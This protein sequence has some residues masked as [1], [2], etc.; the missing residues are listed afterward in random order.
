MQNRRF[1]GEKSLSNKLDGFDSGYDANDLKE[2]EAMLESSSNKTIF[3]TIL[4]YFSLFLIVGVS[5]FLL[6]KED[7]IATSNSELGSNNLIDQDS[8]IK[9]GIGMRE[10]NTNNDIKDL[11]GIKD[12]K[13]NVEKS[14]NSLLT[15]NVVNAEEFVDKS[16]DESNSKSIQNSASSNRNLIDRTGTHSNNNVEN[17]DNSTFFNY[18]NEADHIENQEISISEESPKNQS[19]TT[20]S[21]LTSRLNFELLPL[22]GSTLEL[23]K[24][25]FEDLFVVVKPIDI[26][27]NPTKRISF[28]IHYSIGKTMAG[29][30]ET[31][32]VSNFETRIEGGK[33]YGYGFF[34]QVNLSTRHVVRPY[35]AYRKNTHLHFVEGLVF[36]TG[37]TDINFELDSHELKF[38]LDYSFNFLPNLNLFDI[39]GGVGLAYHKV[40][41]LESN[42]YYTEAPE[43]VKNANELDLSPLS[44]KLFIALDI[45]IY[46]GIVFGIE[47]FIIYQDRT[48]RYTPSSFIAD[49]GDHNLISGVNL[50]ARF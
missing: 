8:D 18:G 20:T 50:T 30:H 48:A 41:S 31:P 19:L 49:Q 29:A 7:K 34:G 25:K 45:P 32:F 2:F 6:T 1:E 46:K 17:S 24:R 16:K 11:D 26:I 33:S 12:T 35:F 3:K 38:G 5:L 15:E 37:P 9:Q 27:K 44:Y 13:N 43:I 21:R 47:P 39:K 28:G 14:Q 4:K 10:V 40:I 22:K 36:Q 23:G 42:N